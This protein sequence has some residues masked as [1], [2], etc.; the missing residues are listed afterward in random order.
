MKALE[1]EH[2]LKVGKRWHLDETIIKV[3]GEFAYLWNCLDSQTKILLA[4]EVTYGR[5]SDDAEMVISRAQLGIEELEIV[6]D[7]LKS[8]T[9][10]LSKEY[11]RKIKHISKPKFTDPL[12]N[13]LVERINE[14]VKGRARNFRRLG[15][16]SSSSEL[17]EGL[18]L[19]YNSKRPHLGL[20][21]RTPM[22]FSLDSS[23]A[24]QGSTPS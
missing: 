4:S 23:E 9:V 21:G 22:D 11:E 19:Y 3:G 18:R 1:K 5:T 8:Y 24:K 6:T 15:D 10:A 2:S 7:G 16:C 14:T 17:F 20:N 12:N 13:N